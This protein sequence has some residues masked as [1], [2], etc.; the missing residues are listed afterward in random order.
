MPSTAIYG[1]RYRAL[2]DTPDIAA[3]TQ[4]LAED[5]EAE[6]DRIDGVV[7]NADGINNACGSSTTTSSSFANLPA[8]SSFSFTKAQSTTKLVVHMHFTAY[9]TVAAS[10]L[11]V[12]VQ[13]NSVDYTVAGSTYNTLSS[14]LQISGVHP[15]VAPGLAAGV[16]T[17]QAR[18]RRA[19]G[20][21]TFNV[22]GADRLSILV[23]EV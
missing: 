14:H 15:N 1:L 17:I 20:T 11:E 9:C 6:L 4:N 12:A 23:E 5:V 21:G 18:W 10:A 16:Y 7:S 22:D 3:G 8:T 2:T 13:V 19:S